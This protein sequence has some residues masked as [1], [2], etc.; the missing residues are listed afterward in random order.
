MP[1]KNWKQTEIKIVQIL[2]IAG[3]RWLFLA[4]NYILHDNFA[5]GFKNHEKCI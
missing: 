2:A 4:N 5:V 3:N 1:R